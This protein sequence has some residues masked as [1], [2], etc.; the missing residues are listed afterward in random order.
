MVLIFLSLQ[1]YQIQI[2]FEIKYQ[3]SRFSLVYIVL[4]LWFIVTH[5][6]LA[7]YN[8]YLHA[9]AILAFLYLLFLFRLYHL[10]SIF[11]F[12]LSSCAA[13]VLFLCVWFSTSYRVLVQNTVYVATSHLYLFHLNRTKIY[14]ILCILIRSVFAVLSFNF[15][16]STKCKKIFPC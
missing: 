13:F 9:L 14:V 3:I 12:T 7:V 16:L 11:Y 6:N 1:F 8:I 10:H 5:Y 15:S 2:A 4:F